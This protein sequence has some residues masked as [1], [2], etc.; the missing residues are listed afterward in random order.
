MMPSFE[1]GEHE[2][3]WDECF[4]TLQDEDFLLSKADYLSNSRKSHC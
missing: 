4:M 1:N 2:M 3:E